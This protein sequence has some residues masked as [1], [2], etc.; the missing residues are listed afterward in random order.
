MSERSQ[1]AP[2]P[3]GLLTL[4]YPDTREPITFKHPRETF[5]ELSYVLSAPHPLPQA[6]KLQQKRLS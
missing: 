3:G 6:P 1:A 5:Y 2:S 4:S